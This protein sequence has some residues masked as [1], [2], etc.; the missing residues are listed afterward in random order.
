MNTK[1]LAALVGTLSLGT[2][3]TGCATTKTAQQSNTADSKATEGQ[4]GKKSASSTN[5]AGCT[6]Y[7]PGKG[8]K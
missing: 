1:A 2:L 8:G 5:E 4:G 3:A 7:D 6:A